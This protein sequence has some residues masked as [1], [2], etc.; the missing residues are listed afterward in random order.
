MNEWMFSRVGVLL[1]PRPRG[2]L[3][4]G[5]VDRPRR[6]NTL[7]RMFSRVGVL[8]SPRPR[9]SL[10]RGDVDRPRRQNTLERMFSRGGVLLSPR[11]RGSLGR[12]DVD[13][14]RRQ[15]T[16]ERMFSRVGVLLSPRPRGGLG[17]GDVDR[18]RRQIMN[19]VQVW[20]KFRTSQAQAS[21]AHGTSDLH[22]RKMRFWC[23]TGV[24]ER[25][26]AQEFTNAAM[27]I[28]CVHLVVV[29]GVA[30][31][32]ERNPSSSRPGSRIVP[33][34]GLPG[35]GSSLQ[36]ACNGSHWGRTCRLAVTHCPAPRSPCGEAARKRGDLGLG[37]PM[38]RCGGEEDA[39][40]SR[41]CIFPFSAQSGHRH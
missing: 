26:R 13:R 4:R 15:N 23:S 36:P 24:S 14:P 7:E 33:R 17:R 41:P 19:E 35:L 21:L 38:P 1:S 32:P 25:L 9:G 16:L 6:Q 20:R 29:L 39:R 8:L 2:S 34:T 12:G 11:P 5:D 22:V 30:V 18:P 3:G 28:T 10:G 31:R 37:P 40:Q 27:F